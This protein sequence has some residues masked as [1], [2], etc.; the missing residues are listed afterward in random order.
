METLLTKKKKKKKLRIYPFKMLFPK[1]KTD[2]SHLL[3]RHFSGSHCQ[4]SAEISMRHSLTTHLKLKCP[5]QCHYAST[6]YLHGLLHFS[7]SHLSLSKI[8]LIYKSLVYCMFFTPGLSHNSK[9]FVFALP[10]FV[11][12]LSM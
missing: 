4:G 1:F 11:P 8:L 7:L 12:G 6:P 2:V 5:P 3:Y 9:V 10:L